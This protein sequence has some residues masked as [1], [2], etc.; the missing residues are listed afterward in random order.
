MS[1]SA[2][3]FKTYLPLLNQKI[4]QIHT[5]K[6][7]IRHT[8][9]RAAYIRPAIMLSKISSE[10][11]Y[12]RLFLVNI[13]PT[14]CYKMF[15]LATIKP[16]IGQ[17]TSGQIIQCSGIAKVLSHSL[18]RQALQ[19]SV[20]LIIIRVLNLSRNHRSKTQKSAIPGQVGT[21]KPLIFL[22]SPHWTPAC[23]GVTASFSTPC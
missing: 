6:N 3:H 18:V 15:M 1:S 4:F 10:L 22:I 17:T 23:A 19:S 12:F 11:Y 20:P 2:T 16:T 21:Q 9:T 7:K 8:L 13:L 5:V 14:F